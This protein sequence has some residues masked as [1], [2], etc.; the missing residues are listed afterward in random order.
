MQRLLPRILSLLPTNDTNQQ[1]LTVASSG[2]SRLTLPPVATVAIVLLAASLHRIVVVLPVQ[3]PLCIL[4]VDPCSHVHA[5]V[6]ISI[7]V[8]V[9]WSTFVRALDEIGH[10]RRATFPSRVCICCLPIFLPLSQILLRLA[11]TEGSARE[12]LQV[13]EFGAKVVHLLL[14]TH[15]L[16]CAPNRCDETS[17]LAKKQA[18]GIGPQQ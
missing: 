2:H 6:A 4:C 9:I 15:L 16:I 12:V 3:N 5:Y 7:C 18:K 10:T 11:A 8:G 13:L 17:V 1:Q 14:R